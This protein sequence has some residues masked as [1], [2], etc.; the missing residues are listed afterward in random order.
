M[1]SQDLNEELIDRYLQGRLSADELQ[2]VQRLQRE[3]PSFADRL[4]LTRKV[5]QLVQ[6]TASAELKQRISKYAKEEKKP[7]SSA[8]SR[9]APLMAVAAVVIIAI[10]IL[11]N[12]QTQLSPENKQLST[13]QVKINADT[14]QLNSSTASPSSGIVLNTPK[15]QQYTDQISLNQKPEDSRKKISYPSSEAP[16]TIAAVEKTQ[17]QSISMESSPEKA[18]TNQRNAPVALSAPSAKMER[19][20]TMIFAKTDS[21]QAPAYTFVGNDFTLYASKKD[22]NA[23][24]KIFNDVPYLYYFDD[25]YYLKIPMP[26]KENLI[27]VIDKELINALRK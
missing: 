17:D 12:W 6:A 7:S 23:D 3:D 20:F 9:F 4:D 2:E 10:G 26:E 18:L 25:F 24:I 13:V 16:L 19:A 27:K 8:F 11:L 22:A 5:S 1:E 21:K 15:D 14:T